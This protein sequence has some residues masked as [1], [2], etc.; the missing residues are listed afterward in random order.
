ML[1]LIAGT[2]DPEG[3]QG[4][5]TKERR[6]PQEV[7]EGEV[8]FGELPTSGTKFA[9]FKKESHSRSPAF[10]TSGLRPQHRVT[11]MWCCKER[12]RD[13]LRRN[14]KRGYGL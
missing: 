11:R 14:S 13:R 2:L 12:A 7:N 8:A 5:G 1:H 6:F 9:A 3:I 10:S 4:A